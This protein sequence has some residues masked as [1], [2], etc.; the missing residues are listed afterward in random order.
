VP[1]PRWFELDARLRAARAQRDDLLAQH[2][3]STLV[4]PGR[5]LPIA[6][7]WRAGGPTGEIFAAMQE[8]ATLEARRSRLQRRVPVQQ[9][10]GGEVLKLATERRHLT[11]LVKMVTYQAESD[12]VRLV[13]PHY[14]RAEQEGRTLIQT[15]LASAADLDVTDTELP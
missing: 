6:R 14:R 10:V 15:A 4:R 11:N 2:G 5:P 8:V 13:A 1:N 7:Q 9:V 3:F 12:L